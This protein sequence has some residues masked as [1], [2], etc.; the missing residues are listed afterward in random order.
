MTGA[1]PSCGTEVGAEQ[2]FC[3]DCGAA[4]SK[5]SATT[6]ARTVTIV[7]SDLQGSTALGE[8]LDPESLR[9]VMTTYIEEMRLVFE[10]HGGTIEKIIGDA[11]VA[12]FGLPKL[13]EDD[14]LRAVEAAAESQRAL[15]AL[16]DHLEQ[17]W[18]VRLVVRT[19]VASG[20]VVV[21][22]A[23]AGQHVLTGPTVAI[24]TAMEQNS[25]AQEVLLADSTFRAVQDA[26]EVEPMAVV[27]PK[28]TTLSIPS[29]R[30]VSVAER[31]ATE[32][33]A[34]DVGGR[35][36]RTCGTDNPDEGQF[37]TTC[38]SHLSARQQ[39][40]ETRKTV[41]VIFADP[42]PSSLD[43][44]PLAPEALRD[45]MSRYFEGMQRALEG[46][47]A[48]VE[49][50]IG[51]AVMAVFGLPIRHEDDALRAVRAARQMQDALP[52]LNAVFEAEHGITLANHIGVNTG[53]VV[54]G[55][56]STGQRLVTGDTVNV[57]AR[58][59][60]AAGS[61]EILLGPL[62]HQLVRDAVQV[63]AVEPLT[64]KG[65]SEP[66]PA[67]RL[68]AVSDPS[69]AVQRRSDTPMVGREEEM[70]ALQAML[71]RAAEER[72]CRLA[73]VVGDAGVG[74]TR[75]VTEFTS[76]STDGAMVIRGRCLPYGDGITFWPLREIVR[77]A[78]GIQ[79][80]D[81]ADMVQA[82]LESGT[83][84]AEVV[85]RLASVVGASE[86]AFPVPELFW[87]A[88][89]FLETLAAERPVLAIIDDIHWAEPTFLE[90]LKSLVESVADASVLLLCTS[91]HELIERMPEWGTDEQAIL[92]V[93]RPLSDADAGRVVES[94][95][96]GTGLDAGVTGQILQ[97]AAGNPLFVEQ[98]LSMLIDDGTLRRDGDSWVQVGDVASLKVPPTIDAL[99]TARLD[100]LESEERDVIEP[101]SVIGQNFAVPAVVD[102]VPPPVAPRV[103][104]NLGTLTGKQLVQPSLE[105]DTD[106]AYRFQHLLVRD[107]AYK[108]L[109]KR[110]RA[111][112]HQRFVA[113]AES[114][115]AAHGVD[116]RDFEEIHG[117]HLET[118]YRYLTELGTINP[119]VLAL[120]KRAS[121]KLASAG[122][123]AMNRGDMPAA[124]SLLRRAAACL[125]A[126]SLDRLRILPE[127]A[128][129]LM[130]LPEFEEAER[131]LTEAKAGAESQ[132][133]EDLAATAE[134]VELLVRQYSN[135]EGGWSDTALRAVGRAIPI[136]EADGNHAGLALASRIKVGVYGTLTQF[137]ETAN[138]AEQVI[139]H[140]QEAGD[141]RLERR[142]S[143]GY[144]QAA[145]FGPTP[146]DE[147][148][149]RCEQ[150]AAGAAG[151]RRTEALV[152]N[153]LAQ[154]YS[155][156]GKFD[157]ARSTW[158]TADTMLK[159]LEMALFSAALS[160]T[161][162][163]IE[164]LAGDLEM[165]EE[166]L[167]RGYKALESMGGAF[168]LS[169]V[170]GVLG[171]VS[172]AQ[173]RLEK[174]DR[175]ST[176][177]EGLADPDDLDAQT[178]WRLLR[179]LARVNEGR[180]D[181]GLALAGEAV[182]MTNASDAPLLQGWALTT[183]A[184]VEDAAG[185]DSQRDAAL[186]RA[187]QLYRAK[188]DVVTA[189]Q[190]ESRLKAEA[191]A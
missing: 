101:A 114:D 150:L 82:K 93:L 15:S 115:N 143:V 18:G 77:D 29:Y 164:L 70:G 7:T 169:G 148:V 21:G 175:L 12:V 106:G 186:R 39:H 57:A 129:A 152:R 163:Q 49:K 41:T 128:E 87:A 108:G 146:V 162:G 154:L 69:V 65:K 185:H 1:C 107:A 183:L 20:D 181:H 55:D 103:P 48:T 161:R 81:A 122:R 11:I 147:A 68:V 5:G 140:A 37:C 144:A 19:G 31:T 25:P 160:I 135:E 74:K 60:Q 78:C 94:L 149:E 123:R 113:W 84:D 28:G 43:G 167:E 191:G 120:G 98:L 24:A 30:L 26:V 132:D 4:L 134:L 142:G 121:D 34:I 117:Y 62:T 90:L 174:V 89:R 157:L 95:L 33:E 10:R 187:L 88:R 179:A 100:L 53:E 36:C 42:K 56:A 50:F 32:G 92:L 66:V 71:H 159:E 6:F 119:E 170:A 105:G 96:G 59:E 190:L 40:R 110:E 3:G 178:D 156:Q 130:E 136:F 72:A 86:T 2:R 112:L 13:G 64:L 111:E 102:L 99:L 172:Y 91:R 189:D 27:T 151:D 188:G 38:G 176:T 76:A 173:G 47:G 171:R 54:A 16:N 145:L 9:E 180:I 131:V 124:A 61:L 14:A 166:V 79:A 141:P 75:L 85:E 165:A 168:L 116:N 139:R 137:A 45:V 127:L 63:E 177:I 109:L 118:A 23:S 83:A 133:D 73:T 155:M 126:D 8:R 58:L 184:D 153:S 125:P 52:L 44:S 158:A 35:T 46:H 182:E 97:A 80:D 17:R 22:E 138:A 104:A 67:F 51:D